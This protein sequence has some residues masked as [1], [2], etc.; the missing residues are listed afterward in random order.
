[1]NLPGS[2]H[3]ACSMVQIPVCRSV[4]PF[5]SSH[6]IAAYFCPKWCI[7]KIIIVPT[8]YLFIG[9]NPCIVTSFVAICI[10][11]VL[12]VEYKVSGYLIYVITVIERNPPT[13]AI[14]YM[15]SQSWTTWEGGVDAGVRSSAMGVGSLA[16]ELAYQQTDV[17]PPGQHRWR[18][19]MLFK[20]T[21]KL[22]S[23][24][25]ILFVMKISSK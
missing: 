5:I 11:Q 7:Y 20:Q 6:N 24:C 1:M 16:G 19:N 21:F 13:W 22:K 17:R 10:N 14:Q 18:K 23:N 2:F 12:L 4:Q 25:V 8:S 3:A 15:S 9:L